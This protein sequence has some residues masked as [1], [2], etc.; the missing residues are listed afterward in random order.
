MRIGS[1]QAL[2]FG[3]G[4]ALLPFTDDFSGASLGARWT[5]ATWSISS[6][7]AINTPTTTGSD[8]VTDGDMEAVGVAAWD[9]VAT[10]TTKDKSGDR[11]HGGAQSLRIIGDAVGDGA[12]QSATLAA[13]KWYSVTS[14]SYGAGSP[15]ST[16]SANLDGGGDLTLKINTSASWQLSDAHVRLNLTEAARVMVKY[17]QRDAGALTCYL[18]DVTCKE[19]AVAQLVATVET[20]AADVTVQVGYTA[21]ST[22]LRNL[23][24]VVLNA[25][26]ATAPTNFV[27]GIVMNNGAGANRGQLYKC[28]NGSYS[29]V[30]NSAITYS[31]GAVIKVVK[32]GTTYTLFYNGAQI[33]SPTTINEATIN[34]NTLHGMIST[35]PGNLLDGFSVAL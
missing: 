28:V 11:A 12:S 20:G 8:L 19:V 32:S 22:V 16:V 7:S 26:S 5:G 1:R 14:W 10:P 34:N 23:A 15:R 30:L 35:V 33:G 4:R 18:D 17:T 13:N 9:D 3:G 21:D 24:G 27:I 25:N 2:I 31:A 6:G 29:L